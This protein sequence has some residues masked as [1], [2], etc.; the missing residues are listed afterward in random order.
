LAGNVATD[1]A[2]NAA[3]T[4]FP[5]LLVIPYPDFEPVINSY[6]V[7]KWQKSWNAEVSNKLHKILPRI[8]SSRVYRLSRRDEPII[9]RLLITRAFYAL[10][11]D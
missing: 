8:G 1:A 11:P 2:A 3:L 7:A 6:A 9:H 5:A 10:S 4:F